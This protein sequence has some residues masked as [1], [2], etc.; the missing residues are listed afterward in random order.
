[1]ARFQLWVRRPNAVAPEQLWTG[2]DAT[3]LDSGRTY[4]Q[5]LGVALRIARDAVLRDTTTTDPKARV[6]VL[7]VRSGVTD[8]GDET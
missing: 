7:F 1:M 8:F 4:D 6:S 2:A 3:V 5:A